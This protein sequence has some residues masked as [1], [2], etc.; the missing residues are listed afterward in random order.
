MPE[1]DFYITD[2]ERKE[3][4]DFVIE[5]DGFFIPDSIYKEQKI[6]YLNDSNE[7][8]CIIN[9]KPPL[10]F[11]VSPL[12]QIEPIPII[13]NRYF[14]EEDRFTLR[15]REGGPYINIG[16]Y[17]GFADDAPIKYKSTTFFYYTRYLHFDSY[18]DE[19]PASEELKEY[20]KMMVKF[21]KSKCRRVTAKDGKKYWVSKTLSEEEVL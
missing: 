11:I 1:M 15:Q 18:V 20:F 13:K 10:F 19:F 6:A 4:L 5:K 17:R 3:L 9:S 12:F 14:T 8:M 2:D 21:L 16:F 7:L